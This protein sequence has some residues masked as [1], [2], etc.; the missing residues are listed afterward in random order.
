MF[1][2]LARKTSKPQQTFNITAVSGFDLTLVPWQDCSF[3]KVF[4]RGVGFVVDSGGLY[5]KPVIV[6]SVVSP[7]V[8]GVSEFL[9][10]DWYL[11]AEGI[12]VWDNP[13]P[14]D[15]SKFL[16]GTFYFKGGFIVDY[17]GALYYAPGYPF[18]RDRWSTT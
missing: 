12:Q 15:P 9:I 16:Q 17:W 1:A 7:G 14:L 2:D 18:Y 4:P 10:R 13:D 3:D 6:D 11:N 8:I 5:S